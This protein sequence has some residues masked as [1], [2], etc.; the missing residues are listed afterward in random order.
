MTDSRPKRVHAASPPSADEVSL[1]AV[2]RQ[3]WRLA[4]LLAACVAA[5]GTA[6]LMLLETAGA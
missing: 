1:S 2:L 4:L 5:A 6:V 3:R